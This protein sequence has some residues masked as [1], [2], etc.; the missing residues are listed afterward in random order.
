MSSPGGRR[1]AALRLIPELREACACV[2][3]EYLRV[4]GSNFFLGL[5]VYNEKQD[6]E[7]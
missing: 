6:L 7:M 2:C 4:P 5:K 3:R 1:T